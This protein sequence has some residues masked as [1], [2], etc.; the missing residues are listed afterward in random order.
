[1]RTPDRTEAEAKNSGT[2]PLSAHRTSVPSGD[3]TAAEGSQVVAAQLAGA[4]PSSLALNAAPRPAV[5]NQGRVV[6]DVQKST[7]ENKQ[8]MTSRPKGL[9][10]FY[11]VPTVDRIAEFEVSGACGE[12]VMKT[13][14]YQ[15]DTSTLPIT[16]TM[17][18]AAGGLYLWTLQIVHQSAERPQVHFGVQ[19]VGH[20]RPWRLVSTLRC[21]R[22]RDDGPW[23][24]RPGGDVTIAVG[25]CVHCEAD[26][27]GI[28]SSLGLF[29]MAINDGPFEIVFEDIPLRDG[30]LQ[31]VVAMGGD[32]TMIRIC[33]T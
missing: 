29:S 3:K 10:P 4:G 23:M 26:L 24:S 28:K 5:W 22:S 7:Q 17:R 21:S 2:W 15:E 25:D 13:G 20:A 12:M 8:V 9:P 11:W 14:N 6:E 33:G 19:G 27:R 30:A 31:P 18:M 16:G 32:G 1:M